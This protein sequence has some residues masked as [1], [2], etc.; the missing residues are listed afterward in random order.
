LI[1]RLGNGRFRGFSAGSDPEGSVHPIALRYLD[2]IGFDTSGLRSKSWDEF[3]GPD[4]PDF[5]FVFTVCDKAAAEPCPV[6]PGQPIT[7]HWGV[8]DPMMADPGESASAEARLKPY[9][10]AFAMLRQRIQ[11]LINLPM[12]SLDHIK[13]EHEVQKIGEQADDDLEMLE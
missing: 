2:S 9:K 6:W 1:N 11:L 10:A 3:N 13:L 7:A 12:T 5:D 4:A 8:E